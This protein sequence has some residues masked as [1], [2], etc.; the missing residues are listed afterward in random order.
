M[1]DF[2]LQGRGALI[3]GSSRGIG[4]G[5]AAAFLRAGSRVVLHG[6]DEKPEG[7]G[8]DA[9]PYLRTDILA[10]G[11]V[12]EL[13]D[14]AFEA[15][16]GLDLLV[17]NA[18]GYFDR[19]VLEM[20]R[21]RWE[22]TMRL[23]VESVYFLIQGFARR[24]VNAKRSGAVVVTSSTNGFQAEY[25][26]TAYDTSKGALVMMTR[27]FALSLAEYGIRVNG[28]APGFIRTPATEGTLEKVPGLEDALEKKIAMGRL[29]TPHDC[30]GAVV[31]LC[32]PA[33]AYITGQILV[34]DGG[35]TVGQ[36]P[37]F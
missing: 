24:L 17:C 28:L 6:L 34:V 9:H 18:G 1:A 4:A 26:S 19:P 20:T 31:F 15:D 7:P 11:G 33:A 37:R 2:S 36:L 3:T 12:E 30:A 32:S 10:D 13:L 16:P 29:G 27:T 22:K 23:N 35:L 5:I 25:E 8:A 14:R 21:D